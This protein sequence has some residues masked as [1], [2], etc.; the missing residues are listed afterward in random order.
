MTI[1]DAVHAA[2]QSCF[3][4]TVKRVVTAAQMVSMPQLELVAGQLELHLGAASTA[5][6]G[7]G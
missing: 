2:T 3:A 5:R 1:A 7:C 6:P 4:T